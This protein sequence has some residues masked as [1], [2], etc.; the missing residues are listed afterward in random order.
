MDLSHIETP[1]GIEVRAFKKYV[2]VRLVFYY[3]KERCRENFSNRS[4][5]ENNPSSISKFEAAVKRDVTAA[6]QLLSRVRHDL[7]KDDFDYGAHFPDSPNKE[8]LAPEN[9]SHR[10]VEDYLRDCI[11]RS[12]KRVRPVTQKNYKKI[13]NNQLIPEFGHLLATDL[14]PG[15]VRDWVFEKSHMCKR[16]TISNILSPFK[17]AM[18]DAVMDRV[19]SENPVRQLNL[20]S[21]ITIESRQSE[22]QVDPFT[23]EEI[24]I[25]LDHMGE[26]VR[27]L[28][29]FAFYTGMR[30]S[31]LIALK[32]EKID[33]VNREILVDEAMVDGH[34]DRLKTAEKGVSSRKILM[35]DQ[36]HEA[37]LRQK[38]HTFLEG[39]FVFHHPLKGRHWMNDSEVRKFAWT[40]AIKRAGLRYRNPYQTR[41]TYAHMLILDNENPWWIANQLGHSGIDML[42][43][44]YGGWLEK[45]AEKYHPKHRFNGGQPL[46]AA[47]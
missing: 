47:Q 40:P 5:P 41:H 43:R 2:T 27:N 10:T 24:A 16:K 21:I 34:T 39:E 7:S 17:M 22:F 6:H 30:T 33:F 20:D 9:K 15:I 37:L 11:A 32:W 42:N 25:L 38:A 3:K 26:Q 14:T 18:D 31:E 4:W 36:A 19:I 29:Q 8:R 46:S 28:F 44:H 1:P 13:I 23:E 45:S 12:K 35:L